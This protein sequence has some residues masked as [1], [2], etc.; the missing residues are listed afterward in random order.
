MKKQHRS[1]PVVAILCLVLSALLVVIAPVRASGNMLGLDWW[2]VD[3]GGG[4]SA[5][6][7]YNLSGTTGQPDAG[8]LAGGNYQFSG[9]FWPWLKEVF[10]IYLPL[11]TR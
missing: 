5:A 9:G 6:S 11:V 10:G 4:T 1:I 8:D 2:T 3:G 7:G